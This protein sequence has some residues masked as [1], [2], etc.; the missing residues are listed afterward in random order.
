MKTT[1]L[2]SLLTLAL[3]LLFVV[4]VAAQDN[5]LTEARIKSKVEEMGLKF[6]VTETGNFKF[7]FGLEGDRSQ[8]VFVRKKPSNYLGSD[9]I[10]IYSPT[11]KYASKSQIPREA[12][13][14][15]LAKNGTYKLG[16]FEL[17]SDETTNA[18]YMSYKLPISCTAVNLYTI[19]KE[20]AAEADKTE[21]QYTSLDDF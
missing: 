2:H 8:L 19:L 10:Q 13:L 5:T 11:M 6:D 20:V 3:Y 15:L 1:A 17:A 16:W 14:E 4:P 21:R 12:M 7:V 18:F 9:F